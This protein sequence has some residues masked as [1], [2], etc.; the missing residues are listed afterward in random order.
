MGSANRILGLPV[1]SDDKWSVES[2]HSKNIV[3]ILHLLV[4]LA[5][6]FRA[7]VRLPENVTA[8][9][10]VVKVIKFNVIMVVKKVKI[11]D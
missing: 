8:A 11:K 1:W 6:H 10:V 5:R 9:V 4:A 2:I 3:P 7:P